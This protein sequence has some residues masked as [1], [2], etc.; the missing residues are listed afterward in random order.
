[1]TVIKLRWLGV[2]AVV[3]TTVTSE[4]LKRHG[5]ELTEHFGQ[6]GTALN[7]PKGLLHCL[8]KPRPSLSPINTA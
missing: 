1:M 5:G 8:A 7:S 2:A 3:V 4:G 6:M